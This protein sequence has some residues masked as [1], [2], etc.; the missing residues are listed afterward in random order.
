MKT[1]G[2]L[3]VQLQQGANFR[4]IARQF[5]ESATSAVGG[6]IGWVIV[7]G[8]GL[9]LILTLFLTPLL[10]N[11]MAGFSKPSRPQAPDSPG[12]ILTADTVN[13][14]SQISKSRMEYFRTITFSDAVI[15]DSPKS[16]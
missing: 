15:A 3:L 9:A 8:L 14:N 2:N 7:G 5:S 13:P 1:A 10:Y 16:L 11:L 12:C 6:D 4:G